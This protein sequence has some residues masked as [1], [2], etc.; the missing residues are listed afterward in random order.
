MESTNEFG[1]EDMMIA[2]RQTDAIL[3]AQQAAQ[4]DGLFCAVCGGVMALGGDGLAEWAGLASRLP[5]LV[6]GIG[7]VVYGAALIGLGRAYPGHIRLTQIILALNVLW[8][9]GSIPALVFNPFGLTSGAL[10]ALLVIGVA[11]GGFAHWQNAALRRL[12]A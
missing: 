6:M 5:L 8:V 2:D 7:L 1:S 11:V 3:F 10:V 9:I 12:R 4:S